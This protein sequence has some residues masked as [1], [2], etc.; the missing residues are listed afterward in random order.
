MSSIVFVTEADETCE[1]GD[2]LETKDHNLGGMMIICKLSEELAIV[3]NQ[4]CEGGCC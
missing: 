1:V 2:S 4:N 3:D